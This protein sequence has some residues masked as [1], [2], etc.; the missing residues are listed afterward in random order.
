MYAIGSG[1]PAANRPLATSLTS[2][3][4]SSPEA[5]A[6]VS[7]FKGEPD[8][9]F[10]Q[11]CKHNSKTYGGIPV[12]D[13]F[14]K[15]RTCELERLNLFLLWEEYLPTE[16]LLAFLNRMRV[17][18]AQTQHPRRKSPEFVY[19]LLLCNTFNT[20]NPCWRFYQ[21]PCG[22]CSTEA[23]F[24][25]SRFLPAAMRCTMHLT[26]GTVADPATSR[27]KHMDLWCAPGPLSRELRGLLQ[28]QNSRVE[29]FPLRAFG[30]E[31]L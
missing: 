25:S 19:F 24:C 23:V 28:T 11:P 2:T 7:S 31:F 6:Q 20:R 9:I 17:L 1:R 15:M 5:V 22:L 12:A 30:V 16:Y 13:R 3:R 4:V 8:W 29:R 26:L 18:P 21:H 14:L 10:R 27:Y